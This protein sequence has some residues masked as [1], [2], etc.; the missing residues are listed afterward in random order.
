MQTLARRTDIPAL[1]SGYGL[2]IADECHHVPAAAFEHAVKQ[3]PARRWLGLTATP[4]RRD[5]LDDLIA[6]QVG[7]TRHTITHSVKSGQD[8]TASTPTAE[9]PD[10]GIG[11]REL[12]QRPVPTLRVHLTQFAYTGK[13]D[14][15]APGGIAA[16]YK[17]LAADRTRTTQVARDVTEAL[18]RGRNCLVLTQWTQ[19]TGSEHVRAGTGHRHPQLATRASPAHAQQ[20]PSCHFV[21]AS[22]RQTIVI[23]TPRPAR[24]HDLVRARSIRHN[25]IKIAALAR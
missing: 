14:P 24:S 21:M 13:A 11:F 8:G 9:Q 1:I 3:I 4:Y 7:P 22:D 5:K 19:C 12:S 25:L 10:L 6:L 23:G 2:V 17:D 18:A 16:I 20:R 15:S